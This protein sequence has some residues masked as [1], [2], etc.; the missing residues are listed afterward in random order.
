VAIEIP[1][2]A[3]DR[4]SHPEWGTTS[5]PGRFMLPAGRLLAALEGTASPVAVLE[6]L[7]SAAASGGSA[8]LLVAADRGLVQI[9]LEGRRIPLTGAARDAVLTLLGDTAGAAP[10]TA[11]APS[12]PG[13]LDP[14]LAAR[15]AAVDAQVQES[16]AHV[17]TA[18]AGDVEEAENVSAPVPTAP[19]MTGPD[20]SEASRGL[21]KAVAASGL[22]LEAHAAQWLRGE[23]T[24][25]QL[26]DEVR[27]LPP[28]DGGANAA[29]SEDRAQRQLDSRQNQSVHVQAFAWLGQPMDL[30]ITRDPE[31]R[32]GAAENGDAGLFQATLNLNL[33][34][35]GT[36]RA[37][38]R[39][40]HEKVGLQL[41]AEQVAVLSPALQDL[42]LALLGRGLSPAA[43]ELVPAGAAS[44]ELQAPP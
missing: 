17:A 44:R 11:P 15:V 35:L 5:P 38:V 28:V 1:R 8:Q 14:F 12:A 3:A 22:F 43:I 6:G 19:L 36:L 27:N 30:T 23:R 25:G 2:L 29:A 4:L 42:A 37:R 9:L 24:L 16:R 31:R 34:R 18:L 10:R 13:A 33:P 40:L 21:E 20:A 26:Q 41:A 32:P 7:R 39:L